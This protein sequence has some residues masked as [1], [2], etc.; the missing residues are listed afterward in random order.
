MTKCLTG[1]LPA[2][3]LGYDVLWLRLRNVF[4]RLLSKFTAAVEISLPSKAPVIRGFWQFM[5][6]ARM[7][8]DNDLYGRIAMTVIPENLGQRP[9]LR[10]APKTTYAEIQEI[11]K[12]SLGSVVR[13][14]QN[15][16]GVRKRCTCYVPHNLSEEQGPVSW[17][18]TTVKWR[19]F[20]Q[21]NRHSTIGTRQ[22]EYHE[23]LPIV[24]ERAVTPHFVARRRW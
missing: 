11:V 18:P 8:E 23:T 14:L 9:W 20:S 12:I 13:I 21:S 7:L 15:C 3:N 1:F 24:G 22:A 10:R 5:S 16:F 2:G 6:R 17:R 19:Q 4:S